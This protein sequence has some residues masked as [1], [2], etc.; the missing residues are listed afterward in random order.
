MGDPKRRNGRSPEEASVDAMFDALCDPIRRRVLLAISDHGPR[1][2]EEF[3]A[4]AFA[5][6]E[7][8]EMEPDI[9]RI[10]LFHSHLPRL[11]EAGYVEWDPADGTIRRG[12]AFADI[13]PLLDVLVDHADDLP[14]DFP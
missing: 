3:T 12:P 14:P 13:V 4:D 8:G 11:A 1:D 5:S 10:R 2:A 6:A 9:L 7:M